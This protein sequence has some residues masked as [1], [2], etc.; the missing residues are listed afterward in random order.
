MRNTFATYARAASGSTA[1]AAEQLG[2]LPHVAR[3]FYVNAAV[4]KSQGKAFFALRP[5]AIVQAAA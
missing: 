3:K 2:N 5:L 1:L 4:T